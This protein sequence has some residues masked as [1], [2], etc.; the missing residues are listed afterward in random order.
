MTTGAKG[1]PLASDFKHGLNRF[2][3]N[4]NNQ[5]NSHSA[6]SIFQDKIML[7]PLVKSFPDNSETFY[8]DSRSNCQ[9]PD[10]VR[11]Y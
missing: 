11:T 3:R 10:S 6:F 7:D 1:L 4:Q 5:T 9:E 2:F 8:G